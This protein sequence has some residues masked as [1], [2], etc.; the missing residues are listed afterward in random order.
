MANGC[1]RFMLGKKIFYKGDG[2][3]MGS[4]RLRGSGMV[5]QQLAL[6][7]QGR[8]DL[9]IGRGLEVHRRSA[10]VQPRQHADIPSDKLSHLWLLTVH[11]LFGAPAETQLRI[12]LI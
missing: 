10:A 5:N 9:R 1:Y 6:L 4:Q 11:Q 8:N 12:V 2:F 3:F 7:Q